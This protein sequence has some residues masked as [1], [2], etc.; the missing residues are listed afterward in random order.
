MVGVGHF[1]DATCDQPSDNVSYYALRQTK[2]PMA[3]ADRDSARVY[4]DLYQ[5]NNRYHTNKQ[6]VLRLVRENPYMRICY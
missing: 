4:Q 1:R 5:N 3:S 6:A 2:S